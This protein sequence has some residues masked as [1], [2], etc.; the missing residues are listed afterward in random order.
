MGAA[1]NRETK[2]SKELERMRKQFEKERREH[3]QKLLETIKKEIQ[4]A[5]TDTESNNKIQDR[6]MEEMKRMQQREQIEEEA[7]LNAKKEREQLY[8]KLKEQNEASLFERNVID[9]ELKK[10]KNEHVPGVPGV[11]EDT[12]KNNTN[13]PGTE[14]ITDKENKEIQNSMKDEE[15]LSSMKAEE[16]TKLA[17][18]ARVDLD[19]QAKEANY[20]LQ[21]LEV[22]QKS[23]SIENIEDQD[24]NENDQPSENSE[25]IR[26]AKINLEKEANDMLKRL[27]NQTLSTQQKLSDLQELEKDALQTARL[28]LEDR[29]KKDELYKI[30]EEE[31]N[32]KR[33]EKRKMQLENETLEDEEEERE[34]Q[35]RLERKRK[36][37]EKREEQERKDKAE[38]EEI[39]K[40][41]LLQKKKNVT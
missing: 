40:K 22:L 21:D 15:L 9:S 33:K 37:Q 34:R 26:A 6:L 18:K 35:I 23:T 1:N 36:R 16:L 38:E 13:T 2:T 17:N 27:E 32:L 3:Q 29:Q 14:N 28:R 11:V 25:F 24:E 39:E 10:Q 19:N 30:Q 4:Q 12:T 20:I 8:A 7:R 5:K 41:K 31:Y